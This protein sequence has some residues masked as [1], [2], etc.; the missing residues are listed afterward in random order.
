MTFEN[1]LSSRTYQTQKGALLQAYYA[2]E[3]AQSIKAYNQWMVG[4]F[5][6]KVTLGNL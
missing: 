6:K 4:R 3:L 2:N 5:N 1:R